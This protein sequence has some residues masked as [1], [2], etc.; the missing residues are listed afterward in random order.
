[1][2]NISWW[3]RVLKLYFRVWF[4]KDN[5]SKSIAEIRRS[6]K[7]PLDFFDAHIFSYS[8]FIR[9]VNSYDRLSSYQKKVISELLDTFPLYVEMIRATKEKWYICKIK[10]SNYPYDVFFVPERF[11]KQTG[12][13]T[14]IYN[15]S[16]IQAKKIQVYPP[17]TFSTKD[18]LRHLQSAIDSY[19]NRYD[20]GY[21]GS[22]LFYNMI[23]LDTSLRDKEFK[24]LFDKIRVPKNTKLNS[25]FVSYNVVDTLTKEQTVRTWC[26]YP[27]VFPLGTLSESMKEVAR[28]YTDLEAR[29]IM[30]KALT[31]K[32]RE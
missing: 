1:M 24:R 18:W 15:A 8:E 19:C 21:E 3:L 4:V 27:L 14:H 25:I 29:D 31:A 5:L 9:Q 6:N 13:N 23:P 10:D 12:K 16:Y 32:L 30:I 11:I 28:I 17:R 26:I 7:T 22:F 2:S 20:L